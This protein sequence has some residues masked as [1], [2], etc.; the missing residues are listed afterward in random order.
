[1]STHYAVRDRDGAIHDEK[2]RPRAHWRSQGL[3][4]VIACGRAGSFRGGAG[5]RGGARK[6]MPGGGTAGVIVRAG[7]RSRR[8]RRFWG[9][10]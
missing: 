1:M 7:P 5:R 10:R 9:T 8:L 3:S 2:S 6:T 4:R